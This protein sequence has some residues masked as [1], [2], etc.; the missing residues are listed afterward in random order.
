M[1]HCWAVLSNNTNN[2]PEVTKLLAWLSMN[3]MPSALSIQIF[4]LKTELQIT[5]QGL[6]LPSTVCEDPDQASS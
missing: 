5:Y 4:K 1:Q 2:K 3:R 6:A